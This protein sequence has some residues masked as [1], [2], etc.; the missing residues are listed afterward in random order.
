M[1]R[2]A[3]LQKKK[4]QNLFEKCKKVCSEIVLNC[5]FLARLADRYSMVNEQTHTMHH[6]VDQ[7]MWQTS[8]SIDFIYSSH[9][10]TQT[11]LSVSRVRFCGRSWGLKIYFRRN[12][13]H[14]SEATRSFQKAGC[15]RNKLQFH[16]I[17]QNQKS[18]LWMQDWGWMVYPHLNYGIWSS[19]F[20]TETRTSKIRV[21]NTSASSAAMGLWAEAAVTSRWASA[22]CYTSTSRRQLLVTPT[23]NLFTTF[24]FVRVKTKV[25]LTRLLH[26]S[27]LFHKLW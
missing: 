19:Q 4:K 5:F 11:T 20:F 18:F 16:T 13:V 24:V 3:Q 27:H 25:F 26:M 6:N 23:V 15:V 1:H 8:E 14:L 2:W 12:I 21:T 9:M 10:W 7:S 22:H 17:Q